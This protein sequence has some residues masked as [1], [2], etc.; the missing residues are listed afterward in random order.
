MADIKQAAEWMQEGKR[1][2]R[3]GWIKDGFKCEDPLNSF[4]SIVWADDNAIAD[5]G[6]VDLLADDWEIAT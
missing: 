4:S 3:P 2:R 6:C 1:V 5:I